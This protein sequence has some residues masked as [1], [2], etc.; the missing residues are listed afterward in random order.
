MVTLAPALD[1]HVI[2]REERIRLTIWSHL[3]IEGIAGFL[4]LVDTKLA[5]LNG[6]DPLIMVIAGIENLLILIVH[7]VCV[8]RVSINQRTC[9]KQ[10]HTGTNCERHNAIHTAILRRIVVDSRQSHSGLV[11]L[12]VT[13]VNHIVE[14][15]LS[16]HQ[17]RECEVGWCNI[18]GFEWNSTVILGH[19]PPSI[20]T[21]ELHLVLHVV[22]LTLR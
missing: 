10:K 8:P 11:H 1:M 2:R 19:L 13:V 4:S 3:G 6:L 12:L 15:R 21:E 18:I 14:L 22:N 20:C 17:L 16:Y 5:C 7:I 9:C